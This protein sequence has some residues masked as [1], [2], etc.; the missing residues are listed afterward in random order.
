MAEDA[1]TVCPETIGNSCGKS[2]F[3]AHHGK[4][5]VVLLREGKKRFDIAVLDRNAFSLLCNTGVSGCAIYLSN[6]R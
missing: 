5:D 2:H 6:L 4:I 1:E 3:R